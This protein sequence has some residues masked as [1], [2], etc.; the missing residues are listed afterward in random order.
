MR[1]NA[2]FMP[3]QM[4]SL[5]IRGDNSDIGMRHRSAKITRRAH[6]SDLQSRQFLA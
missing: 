5:A 3:A 1:L 6:S 4:V 2:E